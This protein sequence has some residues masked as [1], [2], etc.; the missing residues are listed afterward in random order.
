MATPFHPLHLTA[1]VAVAVIVIVFAADP[2]KHEARLPKNQE[3]DPPAHPPHERLI[4]SIAK[5]QLADGV[6]AGRVDPVTAAS[7]FRALNR[8]GQ[9]AADEVGDPAPARFAATED[10]LTFWQLAR[11]VRG[12]RESLPEMPTELACTAEARV[13]EAADRAW[14]GGQP[15]LLPEANPLAV[16]AVLDRARESWERKRVGR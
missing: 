2:S 13:V 1:A 7:L 15:I 11:Y 6:A 16:A 12:R 5:S 4:H 14:P 10:G 3:F 8:D 9:P